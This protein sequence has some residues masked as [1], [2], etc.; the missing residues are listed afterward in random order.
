VVY[1]FYI[2]SCKFF[3]FFF[4]FFTINFNHH[5]PFISTLTPFSLLL[6]PCWNSLLLIQQVIMTPLTHC[7]PPALNFLSHSPLTC[8]Q[9]TPPSFTLIIHSTTYYVKFIHDQAHAIL[10][11][12][13]LFYNNRNI[14]KHTHGPQK[15]QLHTAFLTHQSQFPS[16]P[17]V[18]PYQT[19]EIFI[20]SITNVNP[21]N[22]HN[23]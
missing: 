19:L 8:Q 14:P 20:A 4:S 10:N 22:P 12:I 15:Q 1:Y 16:P 13:T 23:L 5:H 21:F 2:Y 6:L 7:L 18:P 3:L 9:T 11:T 17:L